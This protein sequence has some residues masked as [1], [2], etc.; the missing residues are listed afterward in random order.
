MAGFGLV[1]VVGVVLPSRGLLPGSRG[2][3]PRCSCPCA[4]AV[5]V[6]S[7]RSQRR[8]AVG[9]QKT[10]AFR[11]F[12]VPAG[13]WLSWIKSLLSAGLRGGSCRLRQAVQDKEEFQVLRKR[14]ETQRTMK[15]WRWSCWQAGRPRSHTPTFKL[16]RTPARL[17]ETTS[18]SPTLGLGS[19]NGTSC[20]GLR[21][22]LNSNPGR[23]QGILHDGT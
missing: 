10:A 13:W 4:G 5:A 17:P 21:L 16:A 22:G 9:R 19:E 15:A 20:R 6:N 1:A 14:K 11:R 12:V 8:A 3:A 7:A 18:S 23:A 2:T